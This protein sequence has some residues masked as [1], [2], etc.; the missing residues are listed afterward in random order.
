MSNPLEG[1]LA[2]HLCP[3]SSGKT[4][5]EIPLADKQQVV[6]D[7]G[8]PHTGA[9]QID[10]TEVAGVEHAGASDRVNGPSRRPQQHQAPAR[11]KSITGSIGAKLHFAAGVPV[12]VVRWGG[13]LTF[14]A[15]RR[16]QSNR[17][18][19]VS[20]MKHVAA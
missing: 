19:I 18:C 2:R 11:S 4:L 7:W 17:T 1:K 16:G 14:K 12:K 3:V 5:L 9:T 13:G 8:R 10:F 6:G 15:L 20:L